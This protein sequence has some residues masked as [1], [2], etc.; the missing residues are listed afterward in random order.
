MMYDQALD[1]A[2]TDREYLRDVPWWPDHRGIGQRSDLDRVGLVGGRWGW[3]THAEMAA[4][5]EL[6][7]RLNLHPWDAEFPPTVDDVGPAS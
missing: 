4:S 7:D 3:P 2:A 1:G 5:M 6:R